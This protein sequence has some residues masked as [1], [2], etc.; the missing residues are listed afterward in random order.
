MIVIVIIMVLITLT[1]I[2]IIVIVINSIPHVY[3]RVCLF[4]LSQRS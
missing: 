1:I 3:L 4:V 2:G